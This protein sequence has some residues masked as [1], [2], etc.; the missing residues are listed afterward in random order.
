MVL[1]N[2]PKKRRR[3]RTRG[4]GPTLLPCSVCGDTAPD[5]MHY[6]GVACF[7]CRAFFRRSVDKAH[8]YE[9]QEKTQCT[10]DVSTRRNCQYCRYQKCLGSGMKPSWV[11]NEDEKKER[12]LRKKANAAKKTPGCG[13]PTATTFD[14]DSMGGFLPVAGMYQH[15]KSGF[16]TVFFTDFTNFLDFLKSKSIF[17][18]SGFFRIF[19]D[20]YDFSGFSRIFLFLFV[21]FFRVFPP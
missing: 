20:L 17:F 16:R 8:L 11:L 21:F 1:P 13:V 4:A 10:I 3:G 19:L 14:N 7:S 6:G 15:D 2:E 5:H 18:Y 12:V 9:C